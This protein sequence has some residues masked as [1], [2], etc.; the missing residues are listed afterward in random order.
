M[1]KL[2]QSPPSISCREKRVLRQAF[3]MRFTSV[4]CT[5]ARKTVTSEVESGNIISDAL[6]RGYFSVVVHARKKPHPIQFEDTASLWG[7]RTPVTS[8][9]GYFRGRELKL[10]YLINQQYKCRVL[11]LSCRLSLTWVHCRPSSRYP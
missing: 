4:R 8:I 6:R 3:D 11:I 10:L 5:T 7:R 1:G 9:I 2:R